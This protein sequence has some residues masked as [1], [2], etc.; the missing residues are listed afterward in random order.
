VDQ[1][2]VDHSPGRRKLNYASALRSRA[3]R[4]HPR[5]P[6]TGGDAALVA[7]KPPAG[8]S[9]QPQPQRGRY[10]PKPCRPHERKSLRPRELKV[11]ADGAKARPPSSM[12]QTTY[13]PFAYPVNPA[14]DL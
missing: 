1:S 10:D 7:L 11:V 5:S 4:D 3:N 12:R 8:D 9:F 6:L 14:L 2:A 13:L